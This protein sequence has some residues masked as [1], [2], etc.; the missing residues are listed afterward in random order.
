[1]CRQ[2]TNSAERTCTL[3]KQQLL[4]RGFELVCDLA[5]IT[6][7]LLVY[8]GPSII[9]LLKKISYVSKTLEDSR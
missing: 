7:Q 4:L 3:G 8:S 1:M 9:A 5:V 6:K 2:W